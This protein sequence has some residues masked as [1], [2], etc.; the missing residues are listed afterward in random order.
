MPD[1]HPAP[2]TPGL[3]FRENLLAA[4]FLALWVILFLIGMTIDSSPY[5]ER[6]SGDLPLGTLVGTTAIV[7]I[8]YTLTNVPLLCLL[9]SMLG[10]LGRKATL[11]ANDDGKTRDRT[12]P[13]MSAALRGFFVYIL[14]LASVL[15]ILESPFSSLSQEQY[16]RLAGFS[17]IVSFLVSYNPASFSGLLA[18]AAS[19]LD[20]RL[21]TKTGQG[22]PPER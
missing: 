21:D 4:L 15:V 12:S 7:V 13:L 9:A 10:C 18:R 2:A 22:G 19:M 8:A 17:S 5:R 1:L 20:S 14:I 3:S 16:I 6:M 11:E